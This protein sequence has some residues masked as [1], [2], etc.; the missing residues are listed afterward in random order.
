MTSKERLRKKS[1]IFMYR[2][3]RRLV[4]V[5]ETYTGAQL[6]EAEAEILLLLSRY[7][8]V[9]RSRISF[10]QTVDLL[11]EQLLNTKKYLLEQ[12]D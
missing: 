4:W 9:C 12:N 7:L 5:Q 10:F 11:F 6:V 3:S 8:R 2:L 1:D